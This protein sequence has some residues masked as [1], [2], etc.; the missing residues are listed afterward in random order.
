MLLLQGQHG[1]SIWLWAV[2]LLQQSHFASSLLGDEVEGKAD[3]Y[4]RYPQYP[5]Y[6]S[7]P[8]QMATRPIPEL[9]LT[10]DTDTD[11]DTDT[12]EARP[13]VGATQLVHVTSILRHGAR[14]IFGRSDEHQCWEGYWEDRET[15]VWNCDLHTLSMPPNPERIIQEEG[16]TKVFAQKSAFLFE[17]QYDALKSP[18]S[19]ILNG[20][21]NEGQLILQGYEQQVWNG[22]LLRDAYLYD[23]AGPVE[24]DERLRLFDIAAASSST[25]EQPWEEHNLYLRSDDEQRTLMS[26]QLLMR[27]LFENELIASR[28]QNS[29]GIAQDEDA[30]IFPSIPVHTADHSRDILGGFQSQCPKLEALKRTSEE[31]H[32]YQ[33]FANSQESKEVCAFMESQL[34]HD[35]GLLD[36]LMTTVC[37]DRPLPERFGIYNPHP[38][39]WFNRIAAYVSTH[40]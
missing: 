24:H 29:N 25:T 26:G 13:K 32:V 4:T 23:E 22:K 5:N 7:T 40:V 16:E 9:V 39:S 10:T 28:K 12:E 17:K 38:N 14:T 3:W 6:C 31:S 11:T 15:A 2:F 8:E 36:C 19:N 37:T 34:T 1:R 33:Q 35:P 27:G 30:M 20:T 18:Q 21:C